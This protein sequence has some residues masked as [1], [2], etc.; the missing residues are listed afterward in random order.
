VVLRGRLREPHIARIPETVTSQ[1]AHSATSQ[2]I[3]QM[4]L[5]KSKRV[6]RRRRETIDLPCE[7]ATLESSCD[8][9]PISHKSST[10]DTSHQSE[11]A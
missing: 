5:A 4:T 10:R 6:G 9:I 2:A 7:L 3:T 8:G 1:I 11:R